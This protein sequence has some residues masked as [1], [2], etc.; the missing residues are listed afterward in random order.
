MMTVRN[1]RGRE[2]DDVYHSAS[3]LSGHKKN[4]CKD[5]AHHRQTNKVKEGRKEGRIAGSIRW[6]YGYPS[7][8]ILL[9]I[10]TH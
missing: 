10:S 6:I 3:V 5:A 8:T 1:E 2:R 4:R 9:V 7:D